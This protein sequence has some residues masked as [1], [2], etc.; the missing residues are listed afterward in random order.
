MDEDGFIYIKGRK[1]RMIIRPDGHN[2]FPLAIERVILEHDSVECCAVV[3][4]QDNRLSAGKWPVAF[5][6]LRKDSKKNPNIL[7]TILLI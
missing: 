5:I 1:K 2:V 4:K 7:K 6:V 3:G